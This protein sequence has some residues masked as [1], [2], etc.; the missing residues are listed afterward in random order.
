MKNDK[1][2]AKPKEEAHVVLEKFLVDNNIAVQISP[3]TYAEVDGKYVL[4]APQLLV[5]YK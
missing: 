5:S 3:I 2:I 1:L 4:L